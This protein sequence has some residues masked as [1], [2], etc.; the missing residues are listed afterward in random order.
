MQIKIFLIILLSL[1]IAIPSCGSRS[2][3]VIPYKENSLCPSD[4]SA[5]NNDIVCTG[6]RTK[7]YYGSDNAPFWSNLQVFKKYA[8]EAKSRR[9]SCRGN[10]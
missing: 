1:A 8:L 5:C 2:K 4:I 6:A 9:L 7:P 10:Y 3:N